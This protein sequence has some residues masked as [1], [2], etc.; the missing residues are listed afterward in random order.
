MRDAPWA[1]VEAGPRGGLVLVAV[2]EPFDATDPDHLERLAVVV[3][4]LDLYSVQGRFLEVEP[5]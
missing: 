2:K 1:R 4:A 3:D 5:E